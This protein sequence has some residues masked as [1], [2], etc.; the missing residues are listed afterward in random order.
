VDHHFINTNTNGEGKNV[1]AAV[2]N[3]FYYKLDFAFPLIFIALSIRITVI[4]E[5]KEVFSILKFYR[6]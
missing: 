1:K 2:E 5:K 3:L 4:T 6:P